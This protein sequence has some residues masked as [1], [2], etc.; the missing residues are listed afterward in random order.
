MAYKFILTKDDYSGYRHSSLDT[1]VAK[2]H[3]QNIYNMFVGAVLDCVEADDDFDEFLNSKKASE[4][5]FHK[6]NDYRL[7]QTLET[8]IRICLEQ[9]IA[10]YGK[11]TR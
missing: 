6:C 8:A 4:I 5:F 3:K 7:G 11:K 2:R 10:E 1:E 9:L